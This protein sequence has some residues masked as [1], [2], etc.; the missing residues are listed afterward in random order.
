MRRYSFQDGIR[1][2][3]RGGVRGGGGGN[4]SGNNNG[5]HG[6]NGAAAFNLNGLSS[7]GAWSASRDL[8][9]AFAGNSRY[10]TATGVDS[11]KDQSGNARNLD[12]ATGDRQPLI[13]T[14]GP[15]SRICLDFDG[16]DD[17]LNGATLTNFISNTAAYAIVSFLADAITLANASMWTNH[18]LLA[19]NGGYWGL[20]LK[21]S[22]G[23]PDI[24]AVINYDGTEDVASSTT[25]SAGT[26]YVIETRHESGQLYVRINNGSW[27]AGTA[28]GNT[29]DLTNAMYMGGSTLTAMFNGK[30]FEAATWSS[31][32][33]SGQMNQIAAGF[34]SW[35]GA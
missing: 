24:G 12:Q 20:F 28:S 23:S 18:R 22:G 34:K 9:T 31:V 15:N 8:L 25:I 16:S 5:N 27:S 6:Q 11:L 33:T 10:T 3:T 32:P 13:T 30:I 19:D 29:A 21:D 17:N 2:G 1:G 4:G 14:A 26:A 35:V 7:T